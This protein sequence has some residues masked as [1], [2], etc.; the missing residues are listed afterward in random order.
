MLA[1]V[2]LLLCLVIWG[3]WLSLPFVFYRFGDKPV[4]VNV[5][6]IVNELGDAWIAV[7]IL[8]VSVPVA[9]STWL[10]TKCRQ[11]RAE[12]PLPLDLAYSMESI[13]SVGQVDSVLSSVPVGDYIL[14]VNIILS[15]KEN[16]VR[17]ELPV[18]NLWGNNIVGDLVMK[19]TNTREIIQITTPC[20]AKFI[21]PKSL[22]F[23]TNDA[24]ISVLANG[25]NVEGE[26]LALSFPQSEKAS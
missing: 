5:S 15:P 10:L 14:W 1:Y 9:I 4:L 18:L 3:L 16:Q 23:N 25:Q 12:K 2:A 7:W 22:A 26:R 20:W 24:H 19:D 6:Q 21:I 11:Q 8:M 17:V 13:E